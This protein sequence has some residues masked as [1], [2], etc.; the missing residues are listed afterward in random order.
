MRLLAWILSRPTVSRSP[1]PRTE[2]LRIGIAFLAIN[3][4]L[5][6]LI[7][8]GAMRAGIAFYSYAGLWLGYAVLVLVPCL[9]GRGAAAAV[10]PPVAV[11]T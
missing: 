2:G 1:D 3:A 4:V 10:R 9:V 5:D 6:L 11:R 7:V 8:V